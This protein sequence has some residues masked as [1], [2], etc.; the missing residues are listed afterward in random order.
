[1]SRSASPSSR[2]SEV[3]AGDIKIEQPGVLVEDVNDAEP[4]KVIVDKAMHAGLTKG[5]LADLAF[6]EEPVTVMFHPTQ[7][8]FAAPFVD[9]YVNSRGIEVM[10]TD[11]R[12]L[13]MH[14]VP[15]NVEV[16]MKRKYLEVFARAKHTDVKTNV[17]GGSADGSE[18]INQLLRTINLKYPFSVVQDKNPRGH[19]WLQKIIMGR[20]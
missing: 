4:E 5:Y 13:E 18:P 14:Q 1:M 15:I 16:T 2:K 17:I 11:G 12:W 7:D 19:E 6:N 3:F 9:A 20:A 10:D 8:R